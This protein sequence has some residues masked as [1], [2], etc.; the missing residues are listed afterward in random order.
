ME[1]HEV[2]EQARL[3]PSATEMEIGEEES[4][5][6]PW[7]GPIEHPATAQPL[8]AMSRMYLIQKTVL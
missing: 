5:K 8:L 7:R 3:T 4:P 1:A 6:V 2:E